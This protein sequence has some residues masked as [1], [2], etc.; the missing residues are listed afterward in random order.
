MW[1]LN[2]F[3]SSLIW[4]AIL[5][6]VIQSRMMILFWDGGQGGLKLKYNPRAHLLVSQLSFNNL[7]VLT[8]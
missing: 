8:D 1:V 7:V 4:N 5:G 2:W 6:Q 3:L